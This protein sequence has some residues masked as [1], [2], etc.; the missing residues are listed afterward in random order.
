MQLVITPAES[1]VLDAAASDRIEQLME[2][3][4]LWVAL[5]AGEMGAGYGTR[6]AVLAGPGNNGGDA[7]VA[8]RY[9]R[10]RGAA[11]TVHARGY[12]KGDSSAARRAALQAARAGV[13]VM[14]LGVPAPADLVIDGLFGA[15]FHGSLPDDVLPW[16]G[17]T[18]PVLAIDVPSGLDASDG[19]VAGEAFFADRTVTFHARKVGHLLGEGPER[20]GTLEV[21]PIGLDG[22][23]P[24]LR[25]VEEVDAAVP[26]RRRHAHKWSAGSVLVVGGS[27]GL[28][29]AAML[30]AQSALHAGAGAVAIALPARWQGALAGM[31]AGVMTRAIGD[32]ERF[33]PGDVAEVLDYAGRFD[34]LAVGPGLGPDQEKFV[35]EL[36]SEWEGPM[37]VDADGLNAIADP[38]WLR[39]HRGDT[40]VTPHGGEFKRL[41]GDQPSYQAAAALATAT[42]VTVVLKGNPT[43]VAAGGAPWVVT[44]GGPELATVGT[45][46]VLTGA[47]AAFRA[48]GMEADAAAYGAAFW[49]G[50]AGRSLARTTTVTAEGLVDELGRVLR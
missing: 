15:G 47:I 34:V 3:A 24:E 36:L 6:V 50:R 23:A 18:A 35:A 31:S 39:R 27:P 28:T 42:E 20:C 43:F 17:H 33:G 12:P 2:R 16:L 45:G 4:G 5:T 41:T 9:L 7:Y 40:I 8:A 22:G 29:G 46:D 13:P 44:A 11:V 30:T 25:L 37:V 14:P 48:G 26:A 49:H 10:R 32:G 38:S 19:G 1:A 21:R